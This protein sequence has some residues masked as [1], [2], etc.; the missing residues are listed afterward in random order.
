LKSSSTH[1]SATYSTTAK[2][3]HWMVAALILVQLT[4]AQLAKWAA[5]DDNTLE[6]LALLANHKS[7]GLTVLLLIIVRIGWRLTHR[8]P[9]LPPHMNR[10]QRIASHMSHT[11]LYVLMLAMPLSGLIMSAA[12]AYG[13]SWFNMFEVPKV[14]APNEGLSDA[15]KNA[16]ELLGYVFIAVIVLHVVA[17]IY[18][19]LLVKDDILK[20][21]SSRLSIGLFALLVGGL[22]LSLTPGSGGQDSALESTQDASLTPVTAPRSVKSAASAESW[23]INHEL[24]FI[25][26]TA[27]Q[28]G[29][30]FDGEW[31][32]WEA[33]ITFSKEPLS[34]DINVEIEV[35]KADT[36]D[37]ERDTTL[38]DSDWFD[39]T[40]FPVARFSLDNATRNDDGS[41]TGPG[42]LTIKNKTTP[43]E[44]NFTI[45][46]N[47]G[48]HT[49]TGASQLDRLTLGVGTGEW[50]D[51]SWVGQFVGVDVRVVAQ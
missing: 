4:L 6:R 10:L 43:V 23:S 22:T 2:L 8:P 28:A 9:A 41:Y 40:Q 46:T 19:H 15:A 25:R 24:S 50:M 31:P 18:H 21:M 45:E 38:M 36:S 7:L 29:A 34:I 33:N 35:N 3:F 44:F 20:R 17:A 12:S 13:L 51:T 27:E 1:N 37:E 11:G 48:M 42:L 14:L 30:E 26:F 5:Q 47:N 49:L 32:Q 16:H 39:A